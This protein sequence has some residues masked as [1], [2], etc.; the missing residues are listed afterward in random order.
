VAGP[1]YLKLARNLRADLLGTGLPPILHVSPLKSTKGLGSLL[2]T[3]R[4]CRDCGRDGHRHD[5]RNL[6]AHQL[7]RQRRQ[8]IVFP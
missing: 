8:S 4:L 6:P 7:R 5:R 3:R 2:F 1:N